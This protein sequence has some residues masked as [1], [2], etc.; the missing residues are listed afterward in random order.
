MTTTQILILLI[1]GFFA[2]VL[3]G[4][5]G[6]GGGIVIVPVLVYFFGF[7]QHKAQGTTLFLFVLPVGILGAMNYYKAGNIDIKTALILCSTFVFG[8]FFGSKIT[9]GLDQATVKK[10]FAVVIMII[11]IKMLTD[12]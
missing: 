3:S 4:M 1:I 7:S 10:V 12:K 8:S 9:L 5:V 2:G 11:S 6:I